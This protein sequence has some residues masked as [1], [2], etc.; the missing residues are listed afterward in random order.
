VA[1]PALGARFDQRLEHASGAGRAV[2]EEDRRPILRPQ[3]EDL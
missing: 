1:Q 3:E 2:L